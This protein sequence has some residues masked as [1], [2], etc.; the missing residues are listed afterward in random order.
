MDRINRIKIL[1]SILIFFTVIILGILGFSIIE[2][3]SILDSAYMTIITLSTVG[4]GETHELTNTGRIFTIL[5]IVFGLGSAASV[6]NSLA[7]ILI[8]NQLNHFFGRRAMNSELKKIKDHVI[9][10][11]FGKLEVLLL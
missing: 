2:G 4:F 1:K 6:I 10:C 9:L 5:L 11:G 7:T 8:D 3:W